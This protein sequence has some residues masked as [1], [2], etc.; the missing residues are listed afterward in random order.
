MTLR[1]LTTYERDLV[2]KLLAAL[3][4]GGD[5]SEQLNDALVSRWADVDD[6][7]IHVLLHVK[8]GKLHILKIFKEDGS[9]V[10]RMPSAAD[11][12]IFRP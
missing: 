12:E 2:L 9:D 4:D 1:L 7:P 10:I 3:R 5:V 6:V 8:N 11:L